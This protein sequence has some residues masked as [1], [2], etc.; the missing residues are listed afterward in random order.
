METETKNSL[1]TSA[2]MI[3]IGF[4]GLSL[5]KRYIFPLISI[6]HF[7]A[8]KIPGDFSV[9]FLASQRVSQGIIPYVSSDA[10]PYKYSPSIL[11]AI[12]LLP[13]DLNQAWMVFGSLS[14]CAWL[15][16]ILL[17]VRLN[18]WGDFFRLTLGVILSWKGVLETF[19]YG[20]MEFFLWFLIMVAARLLFSFPFFSG[21]FLGFLPAL[22][23]PWLALILPFVMGIRQGSL[24]CILKCRLK[25][26][27]GYAIA[28]VLWLAVI[29]VSL[30]GLERA[31]QMTRAWVEVLQ[32]QPRDLYISDINQSFFGMGLRFFSFALSF[33]WMCI[34]SGLVM[35]F[36][37]RRGSRRP[38]AS[39]SHLTPWLLWVQLMNPLA[40]RW[41][42]LFALGAPFAADTSQPYRI[43][44]LILLI[45][46]LVLWALQQNPVVRLL[47]WSHW[48]QLHPFNLITA[49]W[50]VLLFL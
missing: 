13:K 25:F 16:V 33:A 2:S 24:K 22:K 6:L 36:L 27:T 37:I 23:L 49:Y 19:D 3:L 46:I 44:N 34:A 17:G 1:A 39:L 50:L 10:S 38:F 11:A 26:L 40:W 43:K 18:T 48:T 30:F 5:L 35:V 41:G 28:F 47:G 45:G 29:P 42:S 31:W 20:Q 14:I 15:A 7:K 12:G 21:L 32:V 4:C 8:F 9:Y